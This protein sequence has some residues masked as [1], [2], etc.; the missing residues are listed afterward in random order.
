MGVQMSTWSRNCCSLNVHLHHVHLKLKICLCA[1]DG[2]SFGK[3]VGKKLKY[4]D[5]GNHN[6]MKLHNSTHVFICLRGRW[7]LSLSLPME[8]FQFF[9][10]TAVV[11]EARFMFECPLYKSFK[12]MCSFPVS[13]CRTS[14]SSSF[15]FNRTIELIFAS[16]LIE[17]TALRHSKELAFW[18]HLRVLLL[19]VP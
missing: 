5:K 13:E 19:L 6:I 3:N 8:L 12:H 16:C 15:S 18:H 7:I 2:V 17:A 11:N 10:E 9:F 1:F 4:F 14:E